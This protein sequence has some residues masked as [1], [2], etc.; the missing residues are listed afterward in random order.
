MKV[1]IK[2]NKIIVEFD[3]TEPEPSKSGKSLIL[4]ST[5]G[6]VASE[7]KIEGKPLMINFNAFIY[8]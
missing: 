7:I 2:G 6:V 4:G 8:R 3:L 5:R 1:E